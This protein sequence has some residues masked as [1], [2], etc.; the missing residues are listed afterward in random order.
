M[1]SVV[2]LVGALVTFAG[3]FMLLDTSQFKPLVEWV[4][5]DNR[6]LRISFLRLLLAIAFYFAA[7]ET[8]IPAF[9]LIMAGVFLFS[10][11]IIPVM[12][13]KRVHKLMAWWLARLHLFALPWCFIS[14]TFGVFLMWLAWPVR[15]LG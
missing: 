3:A 2:F 9:T 14:I 1:G 13:E 7:A 10:A 6:L 15:V 8:R 11:I 4:S 12:G 5:R